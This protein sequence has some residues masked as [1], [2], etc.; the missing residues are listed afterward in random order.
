MPESLLQGLKPILRGSTPG[1]KPR[2]PKEKDFFPDAIPRRP[3]ATGY[4]DAG[5]G[6]ASR[7][8][9]ADTTHKTQCA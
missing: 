6:L 4:L 7:C 3:V 5:W 9:L 1:L 8:N 2:P